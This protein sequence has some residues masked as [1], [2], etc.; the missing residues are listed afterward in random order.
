MNES[1]SGQNSAVI[2]G[3]GASRTVRQV[4]ELA[5]LRVG[6]RESPI[7]FSLHCPFAA[8]YELV[9][10]SRR[11]GADDWPDPVHLRHESHIAI[12]TLHSELEHNVFNS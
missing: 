12:C 3:I 1:G 5:S 10:Q 4:G 8:H 2:S 7:V 9:E 11:Q 6:P